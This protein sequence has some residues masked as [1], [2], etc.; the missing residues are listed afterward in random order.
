[1]KI[2]SIYEESDAALIV[3][4]KDDY[5][6]ID[7]VSPNITPENITDEDV[8]ELIHKL[9]VSLISVVSEEIENNQIL[10]TQPLI[11]LCKYMVY[12]FPELVLDDDTYHIRKAIIRIQESIEENPTADIIIDAFMEMTIEELKKDFQI[13]LVAVSEKHGFEQ[14]SK[15]KIM[16]YDE[17]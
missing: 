16:R 8:N 6:A 12:Q 14:P 4:S 15:T 17:E 10:K 2:P 1:M 13:Q 3:G 7:I 9:S 5:A 11:N